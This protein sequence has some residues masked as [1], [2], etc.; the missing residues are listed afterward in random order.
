MSYILEVSHGYP[1][2]KYPLHG[3]FQF[4]QTLAIKNVGQDVI[5]AVVDVRSIRRW[6]KW[7]IKKQNIKGI[8]IYEINLPV[9]RVPLKY[10][11]KIETWALKKLLYVIEKEKGKPNIMH[12]HF[13]EMGFCAV[14]LKN[15]FNIPVGIT[16]HFS[17]I[18]AKEIAKDVKE[19]YQKVYSRADKLIAV[20]SILAQ[21]IKMK[22]G[23]NAIV[24]NNIVDTSLF[25]YRELN[26][27]KCGDENIR[28]I[29]V[30]SLDYRKGFD[31]LIEAISKIKSRKNFTLEIYGEGPQR[32][33]LKK[34]IEELRLQNVVS[35]K[36]FAP[37]KYLAELYKSSDFFVLASRWETFGVVYI[38][39]LA[40]GLP[41]I[42]TKCGGP[43]DF[44]NNQNGIL[45]ETDNVKQLTESIEQM[46]LNI[47][48][49]D[50]DRISDEVREKFSPQFI[51]NK[52]IQTFQEF[53]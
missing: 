16:E 3:I 21:N 4:D 5:L 39:A 26:E 37:R 32:D 42:A 29:S 34:Q 49:Y 53:L 9:G 41:V 38:E 25:N 50:K 15:I 44:V 31:I 17:G 20:S 13:G 18:N 33:R 10:R 43:E 52:I 46:L 19:V 30:G 27:L 35:L 24:I 48:L 45:I 51:A 23:C 47:T 11:I 2:K 8:D 22:F 40:S 1:T 12:A 14:E 7:G 36:G 6:R 28:I